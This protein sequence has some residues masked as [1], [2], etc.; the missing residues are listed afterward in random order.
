VLAVLTNWHGCP[1][2]DEQTQIKN[3]FHNYKIKLQQ[4]NA[5]SLEKEPV[6]MADNE[7]SL[8]DSL[9]AVP[10]K[11]KGG[12]RRKVPVL[13]GLPATSSS[14]PSGM[15]PLDENSSD[16]MLAGGY[17]APMRA[18]SPPPHKGS[19]AALLNS[20]SLSPSRSEDSNHGVIDTE[21]SGWFSQLPSHGYPSAHSHHPGHA[22]ALSSASGS[23]VHPSQHARDPYGGLDSRTLPPPS[24]S[25]FP[26]NTTSVPLPPKSQSLST[27]NLVV[28]HSPPQLAPLRL[29]SLYGTSAMAPSSYDEE[30][31]VDASGAG[32]RYVDD[33]DK[34]ASQMLSSR[35]SPSASVH[36]PLIASWKSIPPNLTRAVY[37]LRSVPSRSL[38]SSSSLSL[39]VLMTGN[40]A[41]AATAAAAANGIVS[42]CGRHGRR[43]RVWLEA[44]GALLPLPPDHRTAFHDFSHRRPS[45]RRHAVGPAGRTSYHRH[46]HVHVL[47]DL[48]CPSRLPYGR[49][50]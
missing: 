49:R 20:P 14:P 6:G 38:L 3:Y 31:R 30:Y 40:G 44:R 7:N 48:V 15:R 5:S 8:P 50:Q 42:S 28:T 19:I 35:Y 39:F 33:R 29:P 23:S 43:V 18:P 45:G 25:F 4:S 11:G 12:R 16:A 17:L 24:G 26:S 22:P 46:G 21:S 1:P 13:G 2:N 47:L 32:V 36:D 27:T 10:T 37:P 41:A 9:P 34:G